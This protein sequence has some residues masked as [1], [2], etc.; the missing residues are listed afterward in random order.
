MGYPLKQ[1]QAKL[2]R[3]RARAEAINR[4]KSQFL[5][6]VSHEIQI[7]NGIMGFNHR[8]NL[9]K[10]QR[11]YSK[12]IHASTHSLL[13]LFDDVVDL[14]TIETGMMEIEALPLKLG[15]STKPRACYVGRVRA[16]KRRW[17]LYGS[18]S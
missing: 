16:K 14:G 1:C 3:A 4:S 12:L 9:T 13:S 5:T 17:H 15:A 11:D 8:P 2:E 10:R 18:R 6:N 7:L